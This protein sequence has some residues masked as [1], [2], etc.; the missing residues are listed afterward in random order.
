[1][2][3]DKGRQ[4]A[5]ECLSRSGMLNSAKKLDS[6]KEIPDEQDVEMLELDSAD[7]STS[8]DSNT[9]KGTYDDI[10]MEFF[11]RVYQRILYGL[12]FS[13]LF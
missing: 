4:V 12:L 11:E 6:N 1:M 7:T 3:S 9:K 10:P 5:L 2:L 13:V 8:S